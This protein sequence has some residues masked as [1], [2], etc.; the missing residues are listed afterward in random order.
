[1]SGAEF[2]E[3]GAGERDPNPFDHLRTSLAARIIAEA[4]NQDANTIRPD[5]HIGIF[6]FLSSDDG[7][8]AR[9]DTRLLQ[10]H[11]DFPDFYEENDPTNIVQSHVEFLEDGGSS[12]STLDRGAFGI[13]AGNEYY[14]L[15]K[16]TSMLHEGP[17]AMVRAI[18]PNDLQH[19]EETLLVQ[20]KANGVI[21]HD[22][23]PDSLQ[24]LI[25]L[26]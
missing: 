26:L 7:F 9:I 17:G 13:T 25:D 19:S 24:P 15:F 2:L 16:P 20:Y 8:E 1:M 11:V 4:R 22:T 23:V 5:G 10:S 6:V 3:L 14:Y 18:L 21:V 12:D